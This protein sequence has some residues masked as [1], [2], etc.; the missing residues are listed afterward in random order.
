M[1]THAHTDLQAAPELLGSTPA[2]WHDITAVAL[3]EIV[4]TLAE[5]AEFRV[6]A[7]G[8]HCLPVV[9]VNLAHVG[10][11]CHTVHAELVYQAHQ[12]AQAEA[13]AHSLRKGQRVAIQTPLAHMRV[14]LPQVASITPLPSTPKHP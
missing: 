4:G 5:N 13:F 8:L 6:K 3:A 10:P 1:H 2:P 14:A 9:C 11:Q 7:V 12:R